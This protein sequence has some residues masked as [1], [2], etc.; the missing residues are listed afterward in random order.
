[1]FKTGWCA[2]LM[3]ALIFV[4]AGCGSGSAPD[5]DLA[6]IFFETTAVPGGGAGQ[7]YNVVILFGTEGGATLPD[8]FT[9]TEGV[10]PA[11]VT[12]VPDREDADF[13][14]IPD[15]DGAFTGNARLLGFPREEGS[16]TF[17]VKAIATRGELPALA[18]E[19]DFVINVNEGSVAILSPTALEGTTDPAVPAFPEVIPFVNPANP[20]AFF[21]F[22]WE[23]AGGSGNLVNAVYLPRE[24]ELSV[25]D[26]A[27]A[28]DQDL[29]DF[30]VIEDGDKFEPNFGDG[31]LFAL[32]AGDKVQIGGFQSPRVPVGSIT[33]LAGGAA[34]ACRERGGAGSLDPTVA[35]RHFQRAVSAEPRHGGRAGR[36]R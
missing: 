4:A 12:L 15:P 13:D 5:A 28:A 21:S 33:R 22:A 2:V 20:S 11:G 16:F 32:Q 27:V 36:R 14:G 6:A 23:V 24:L 29:I 26:A 31:G 35:R 17:T 1:M 7:L 8:Q 34:D 10:L 9:L 19:Q 3:A 18:A 25:F 30:D